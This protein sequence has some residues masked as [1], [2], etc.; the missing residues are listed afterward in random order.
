MVISVAG[1][2]E[3]QINLQRR[4]F[5]NVALWQVLWL[6]LVAVVSHCG[7]ELRQ[8]LIMDE[9]LAPQIR[10]FPTSVLKENYA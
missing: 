1:S 6:P 3:S 2:V 8:A 7:P 4:F 10:T 5:L 9:R